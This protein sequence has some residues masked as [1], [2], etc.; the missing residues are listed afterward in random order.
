[1]KFPSD[2]LTFFFIIIII[3][4]III[5]RNYYDSGS[6]VRQKFNLKQHIG[7]L[8]KIR[9]DHDIG[10]SIDFWFLEKILIHGKEKT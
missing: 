9:V 3:I 8:E 1:M 6:V 10:F 2:F 4:I 7:K 5:I